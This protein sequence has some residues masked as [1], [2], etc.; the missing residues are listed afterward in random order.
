MAEDKGQWKLIQGWILDAATSKHRCV[1]TVV[2][3]STPNV[4]LEFQGQVQQMTADPNTVG[5]AIFQDDNVR[6]IIL[7]KEMLYNPEIT[8][9]RGIVLSGD[10]ERCLAEEGIDRKSG[11][12]YSLVFQWKKG[13]EIFVKVTDTANITYIIRMSDNETVIDVEDDDG[14]KTIRL[15][16]EDIS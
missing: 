9:D 16:M 12:S 3:L 6:A 5:F 7:E 2:R 1:E 8:D 15:S 4:R 14:P 13:T 11:G 10:D